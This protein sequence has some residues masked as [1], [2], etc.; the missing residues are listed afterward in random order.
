[1]Q[2]IL[3]P[4]QKKGPHFWVRPLF[5][6]EIF[7]FGP[8]KALQKDVPAFSSSYTNSEYTIIPIVKI[9][10]AIIPAFR[11]TTERVFSGMTISPC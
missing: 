2:L 7:I 8:E 5:L 9:S 3:L 6:R 11:K 10:A 1:M 4:V